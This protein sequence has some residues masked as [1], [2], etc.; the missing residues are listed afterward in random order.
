MK[1]NELTI[2]PVKIA[3]LHSIFI[4][5]ICLVFGILNFVTNSVLIGALIIGAGVIA[6]AVSFALRKKLSVPTRGFILS[7]TQ[8]VIIIVMS[9]MKHE[10]QD[11]FPLILASMA[12]ATIYFSKRCVITHWIL[13]DVVCL[14]GLA[15]NDMFYGGAELAPLIKGIIG[16]NAGAFFIMYLL[17]CSISY[18]VQ[19]NNAKAESDKLVEEVNSH[20]EATEKLNAQQAAVV[21]NIAA[22]SSTLNIS[23]DRINSIAAS[24][25]EAADTQQEA[26]IN[27]SE[28][29]NTITADTN[30]SLAAA[31]KASA[32]AAQSTKLMSE[33]NEE[34]HKMAAAMA[35]IE[36]SSEKIREIVKT[37]EDIAFQTNILALNASIEAAR[38]GAAGKGFAVV[39]DEVRNLAGKS[40]NAVEDTAALIDASIDAVQRGREISE[41][42]AQRMNEV[43]STADESAVYADSI[44]KL[45]VK[46]ADAISAV[47]GRIEQISTI[48]GNTSHTA[49]E[50]ANAA[51]EVADDTHKLD[52]IVS[53]FK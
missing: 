36:E 7:I 45:T 51:E 16:I 29:I 25:K 12:M 48:I 13:M 22:I 1:N 15:L 39:A 23:G 20:M 18:I 49:I 42:V 11:M 37:I 26:I 3:D 35:D 9:V 5:I 17:N 30:N 19:A 38:A 50:C 4:V 14:A 44:A 21:E 43:I 28:D 6:A 8:L 33:S 41:N 10:L 53:E 32:S 52:E 31:E 40:Q 47:R 2:V 27:I 24:I 34:M 46:Q